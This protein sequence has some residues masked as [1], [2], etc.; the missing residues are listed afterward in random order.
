MI[1]GLGSLVNDEFFQVFEMRNERI[2]INHFHPTKDWRC[3]RPAIRGFELQHFTV[4]PDKLRETLRNN[5][6]MTCL[7][8][9]GTRV[10]YDHPRSTGRGRDFLVDRALE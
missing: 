8:R 5:T 9:T 3:V 1:S 6:E 4:D 7:H 2:L 10:K